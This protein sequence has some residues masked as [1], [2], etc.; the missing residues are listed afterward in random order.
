M[1]IKVLVVHADGTQELVEK[2]II[3]PEPPADL[4]EA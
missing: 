2:E 4:P 3:L 1:K